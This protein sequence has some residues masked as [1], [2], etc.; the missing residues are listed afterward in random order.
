MSDTGEERW[1]FYNPFS[2]LEIDPEAITYEAN[3]S[4]WF[5][6]FDVTFEIKLPVDPE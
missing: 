5:D 1:E 3:A 4:S 6:W 2:E